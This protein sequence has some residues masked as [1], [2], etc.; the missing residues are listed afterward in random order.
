MQLPQKKY[1]DKVNE[2]FVCIEW[3][4]FGHIGKEMFF[5]TTHD[6]NQTLMTKIN[7]CSAHIHK[8]SLTGGATNIFL[9]ETAYEYVSDLEFFHKSNDKN[10]NS[11]KGNLG[12]RYAVNIDCGL[13]LKRQIC[14]EKKHLYINYDIL[15]YNK[16]DKIG[17]LIK[18]V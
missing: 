2:I 17:A 14:I 13:S 6:W 4:R 12:G 7:E 18:I 1:K 11:L 10:D 5:G 3:K 9:N 8:R 15:V 16:R